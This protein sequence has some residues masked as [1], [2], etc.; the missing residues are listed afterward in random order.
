[1]ENKGHS[2]VEKT[3][4]QLAVYF[5][6]GSSPFPEG[7]VQNTNSYDEAQIAIEEFL[8]TYKL[9]SKLASNKFNITLKKSPAVLLKIIKNLE[10]SN[11]LKNLS[12]ESSQSWGKLEKSFQKA[13]DQT[14]GKYKKRKKITSINFNDKSELKE[15][16]SAILADP[17]SIEGLPGQILGSPFFKSYNIC[18]LA[19][20]EKGR[21]SAKTYYSHFGEEKQRIFSAKEFNT[22]FNKLSRTK[23]CFFTQENFKQN[24]LKPVGNFLAKS[25]EFKNYRTLIIL[26]NNSF[27]PPSEEEQQIFLQ[28]SNIMGPVFNTLLLEENNNKKSSVLLQC[29]KNFPMPLKVTEENERK[30]L[31]FNGNTSKNKQSGEQKKSEK[32]NIPLNKGRSLTISNHFTS[33]VTSDL[34]H[35]HRINLLGELL[36]T[37]SHEL[38][39]PLFGMKLSTEIWADEEKN[40][41]IK[42]TLEDII[43]ATDRCQK[44]ISNFSNLYKKQN[45]FEATNLKEVISDTMT[46]AK[47]ETKTIIK[48]LNF[49]GIEKEN[50]IILTNKT[51]LSQIIFNLIINSAQ[52]LNT[53]NKESKPKIDVDVYYHKNTQEVSILVSDNGPGIPEDSAASLFEPFFTTKNS[54]TGLGL[55]ICKNLASKL[56]GGLSFK[57]NEN[58]HGATFYLNLPSQ[59]ENES[60]NH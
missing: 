2:R 44:I 24:F 17:A 38:S 58:N 4:E 30:I 52:A 15:H 5:R 48:N 14:D 27:L 37:L 22:F 11:K 26:S 54:G 18:Q 8:D 47:S 21:P 60:I 49:H 25:T 41:E 29:L 57:N 59:L 19:F 10:R 39:N 32:I 56:G 45:K 53:N 13:V 16:F 3:K 1:M 35:Y 23:N 6:G 50:E 42:E 55:S 7:A 36:N 9:E 12:I 31:F 51:W 28:F 40:P 20:H 46:L 34:Y 43:D 33:G